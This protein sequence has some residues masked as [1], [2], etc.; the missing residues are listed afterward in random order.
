M[1]EGFELLVDRQALG[2]QGPL[3]MPTLNCLYWVDILRRELHIYHRDSGVDEVSVLPSVV[4]GL[5]AT[6]TGQLLAAV[7]RGFARLYPGRAALEAVVEVQRGDRMNGGACDPAGRFVAGTLTHSGEPGQDALYMLDGYGARLLVEG[8]TAPGGIAWS[9]DGATMYVAHAGEHGT[10]VYDYDPDRARVGA[11][12]RWVTC[13]ES[14]GTPDGIAVDT[15]G[16]VWVAMNGTGR[17]HR[18]SPSGELDTVLW[19]PTARITSLAFGGRRLDELYVVSAC[20][21]ADEP[22]LR[23]DP[24]AGALFRCKPGAVGWSPVAWNGISMPLRDG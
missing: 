4:T 10:W 15:D 6:S 22:A 20:A 3:W 14:D 23:A 19:A 5:A 12:R 17:I 8:L 7:D 13:P 24:Y 18:Y 2:G 1:S 11:G 21:G 9:R 16:C